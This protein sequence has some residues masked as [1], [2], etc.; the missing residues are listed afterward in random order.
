MADRVVGRHFYR[1]ASRR[2]APIAL[3]ETELAD[4]TA[5]EIHVTCAC[6]ATSKVLGPPKTDQSIRDVDMVPT[7]RHALLALTSRA[8][9]GLVFPRR[10]DES[11]M[12]AYSTM[13]RAWRTTLD[14]TKVRRL[15]PYDMRH[16]FASLLIAAGRNPLYVSKQMGHHSPAFIYSVY[17]H[18]MD[19][20]PRRQ[21]EWIDEL[22]FPERFQAALNLHLSALR[23]MKNACNP[24]QSEQPPRPF[25]DTDFAAACSGARSGTWLG[26]EDS[27]P[28]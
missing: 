19:A 1:A 14:A 17:G 2:S 5:S 4:F 7:V 25:E 8:A 23:W 3:D 22:V 20:L 10:G 15:R 27:N 24:V 13:S 16:I 9:G 28:R 12:F 21:V 26:E 6:E 11:Q 18:L